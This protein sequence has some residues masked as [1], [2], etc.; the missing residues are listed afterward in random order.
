MTLVHFLRGNFNKKYVFRATDAYFRPVSPKKDV[1][2]RKL[3]AA[4]PRFLDFAPFLFFVRGSRRVRSHKKSK[5]QDI[6]ANF[7]AFYP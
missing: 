2:K 3:V 4:M 5:K 7:E 1:L 6:R